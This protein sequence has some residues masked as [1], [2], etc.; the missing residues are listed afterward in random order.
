MTKRKIIGILISLMMMAT[1]IVT[2]FVFLG[3]ETGTAGGGTPTPTPTPPG[4]VLVESV[5]ISGDNPRAGVLGTTITLA[6]SV[7]FTPANPANSA[8]TWL[9]SNP[10][11]ATVNDGGVVTGVAVGST[12]ITVTSQCNPEASHTIAIAFDRPQATGVVITPTSSATDRIIISL[13]EEDVTQ[14]LNAAVN[15]S[16][17]TWISQDV[18]WTVSAGTGVVSVNS[19]GLVTGL[20]AGTA[21]VTATATHTPPTPALSANAYIEVFGLPTGAT[22]TSN[23]PEGGAAIGSTFTVSY[24]PLS[25]QFIPAGR[26]SWASNN[27]R[28]TV[29][30]NGLVTV[31]PTVPGTVTLTATFAITEG[32]TIVETIEVPVANEVRA[33]GQIDTWQDWQRLMSGQ[34]NVQG[35]FFLTQDIDF[36]GA[37][38]MMS[39]GYNGAGGDHAFNGILDGRGFTLRNIQIGA[40]PHPTQASTTW[41]AALFG[42]TGYGSVIRNLR[43]ENITFSS[44]NQIGLI[45]GHNRGL[46]ENVF[47]Q[48]TLSGGGGSSYNANGVIFGRNSGIIRNVIAVPA[49]S[50]HLLGGQLSVSGRAEPRGLENIFVVTGGAPEQGGFTRNGTELVHTVVAQAGNPPFFTNIQYFAMEDIG[51]VDFSALD[52]NFWNNIPASGATALPSLQEIGAIGA[53]IFRGRGE[54]FS[55]EGSLLI[56]DLTVPYEFAVVLNGNTHRGIPTTTVYA[57]LENGTIRDITPAAVAGNP[58]GTGAGHQRFNFTISPAQLA[59]ATGIFIFSEGIVARPSHTVTLAEG[60]TLDHGN[61]GEAAH[62]TD[63]AEWRLWYGDVSGDTFVADHPTSAAVAAEGVDFVFAFRT[64]TMNGHFSDGITRQSLVLNVTIGGTPH[65]FRVDAAEE[66][67]FGGTPRDYRFRIPAAMLTGAIVFVSLDFETLGDNFDVSRNVYIDGTRNAEASGTWS[68]R[69]H[70]TAS[71]I[72]AI[73]GEGVFGSLVVGSTTFTNANDIPTFIAITAATTLTLN[74]N[75]PTTPIAAPGAGLARVTTTATPSLEFARDASTPFNA[76]G[77]ITNP[78]IER[79]LVHIMNGEN[80]IMTFVLTYSSAPNTTT[81]TQ[82]LEGAGEPL[83]ITQSETWMHNENMVIQHAYWHGALQAHFA[84]NSMENLFGVNLHLASQFIATA[85]SGRANSSIT[86]GANT[87]TV[88]APTA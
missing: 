49:G 55:I 24:A 35:E 42:G 5:A 37:P 70:V 19:D 40:S 38:A 60:F 57:I 51:N 13:I 21:T 61:S 47:A 74:F 10:S 14:Q 80:I 87:F 82:V 6:G 48:G 32:V 3:C 8:V 65:Q 73:V 75:R 22:L 71:E 88:A 62:S 67:P 56:S 78:D 84:A 69:T 17:N 52:S 86:V 39:V 16:T 44:P 9:S 34:M 85:A 53:P 64:T 50:G 43:I 83:V 28:I 33:E 11:V 63:A 76:A 18:V 15:P 41:L 59:N 7:V 23:A 31:G 46:I 26:V 77:A 1:I 30:A 4:P 45:V 81:L 2:S 79:V 68:G 25:G 12:N 29:D 36:T 27:P 58:N 54:G 72:L 20:T 66:F